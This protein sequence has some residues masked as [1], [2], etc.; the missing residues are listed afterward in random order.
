MYRART[1]AIV[2]LATYL[3]E[4]NNSDEEE[5]VI[6]EKIFPTKLDHSGSDSSSSSPPPSLTSSCEDLL[7]DMEEFSIPTEL[8]SDFNV[9]QTNFDKKTTP[10]ISNN[11]E[12]DNSTVCSTE[13]DK[14]NKSKLNAVIEGE[15]CV[16]FKPSSTISPLTRSKRKLQITRA[17][18]KEEIIPK[19]ARKTTRTKQDF[20]FKEKEFFFPVD[21]P[22]NS[23]GLPSYT[24]LPSAM[25]YFLKFFSPNLFN[26]IVEETNRFS[27][28]KTGYSI[29]LTLNE[30]H[31]FI[32]IEILMGIIKVPAY[33]D[34][35]SNN[36]RYDKIASIMPLK[37]YQLIRR[38]L[39]FSDNEA[40]DD[41]RYY[42]IR[43]VFESIRINC[44]NLPNERRQSI[45]EM[46]VPFK[47][48]RAGSRKQYIKSKP[49]KWGFKLFIRAGVSGLI[50]DLLIYDG[51]NTF[52]NIH[53]PTE[54]NA[55]G[56]G[57]K[58]VLALCQT[59]PDPALS[60]V[61]FDNYFTSLELVCR[62]REVYGIL[63]LGTIRTNRIQCDMP[64]SSRKAIRGTVYQKCDNVNKIVFV[65]W[66][67]NKDVH[68]VSNYV[69]VDPQSTVRRYCKA[70]N[71]K[72]EI[73]CPRIVKDYN[74]HMGGVDLADML[75]ALYRT[76]WKANKWYIKLF[77]Q[78][79]DIC[80]VN[81]WNL[82]R[83]EASLLKVNW[84]QKLKCFRTEVADSLLSFKKEAK[85]VSIMGPL[86]IIN[87]PR[88]S[89]P[90][91][92]I[93]YDKYDHF[94]QPTQKGRCRFCKDGQTRLEC[95]KCKVR[96]CLLSE[97]NCFYTF[98]H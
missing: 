98:H 37:R 3:P 21:I 43:N 36:F 23:F 30:L 52:Q 12:N 88:V 16:P 46:M 55:L 41:D 64:K 54:E 68:L 96:L 61:Y 31:N 77:A 48:T 71:K 40:A 53:F 85:K 67:D 2:S 39:H 73:P 35:W 32:A 60:V 75:I 19:R 92:L 1:K 57:A 91:D 69:G 15:S 6:E 82:K 11:V 22:E 7:K 45:D 72:I 97:R 9:S 50:Y 26:L 95:M 59:I 27:V 49:K 18:K 62:L 8:N 56:F 29:N 94:P 38:F 20:S 42:K 51:A 79:L 4:P 80:I 47:G 93:R 66:V 78:L 89:R 86:C 13:T 63:C 58:T 65:K 5:N 87:E 76:G 34:Y 10:V 17:I 81:A 25:D 70:E 84:T 90:V 83:R 28:Q 74:S 24:E 33:V 44:N 14:I